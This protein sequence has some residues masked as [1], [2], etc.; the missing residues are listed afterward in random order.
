MPQ[1]IDRIVRGFIATGSG[2]ESSRVIRGNSPGPRWQGTY[3][4]VLFL[5][6]SRNGY[7]IFQQDGEATAQLQYYTATYSV[8]WYRK[9]A[10]DAAFT[11]ESWAESENGLEEAERL[12]LRVNFPFEIKNIDEIAGDSFEDRRQVDLGIIYAHNMT[13]STEYVTQNRGNICVDNQTL[14]ITHGP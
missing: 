10:D 6:R 12:K 13:Q 7:P 9:G 3:A 4:S 5:R 8:Q 11:F 14:E 1:E 2:L